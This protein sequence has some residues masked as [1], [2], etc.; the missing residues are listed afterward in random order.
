MNAHVRAFWQGYL[1][2]LAEGHPHRAVAPEVFP[3]GDSEA[4]ADELADLVL[5]GVKRATTSLAVEFLAVGDPLPSAGDVCIVLGGN[6]QPVVIIERIEVV[7]RP[8]DAVDARY[9]ACE[10]E[11]DGSLTSWRAGHRAY[12]QRTCKRLGGEFN[13]RTPV[14][15]QR[16]EV[17]WRGESS[18]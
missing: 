3:F 2:T 1:A 18:A 4:L 11:G 7:Q 12:F 8:F 9:A 5:A 17:I 10:G 13:D 15:C 14:L 6:G 16:F